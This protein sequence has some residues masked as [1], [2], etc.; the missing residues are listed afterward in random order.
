[1][2]SEL[3]YEPQLLYQ[4]PK[5]IPALYR[6]KFDTCTDDKQCHGSLMCCWSEYHARNYFTGLYSY[7]YQETCDYWSGCS[8]D[9][10]D[11]PI[12]GITA[13]VLLMCITVFVVR[14]CRHM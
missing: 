6:K 12:Y 14:R 11:W 9:T 3:S 5:Y 8:N 4:A 2:D 7:G 10:P 1:M 13:L